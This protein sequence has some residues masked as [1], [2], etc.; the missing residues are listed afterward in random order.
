MSAKSEKI[1]ETT[2]IGKILDRN[3]TLLLE[4]EDPAYREI[5]QDS[6]SRVVAGALLSAGYDERIVRRLAISFGEGG[7]EPA[8]PL[9]EQ[10]RLDLEHEFGTAV[11]NKILVALRPLAETYPEDTADDLKEIR[12]WW[13]GDCHFKVPL[14]DGSSDYRWF[15]FEDI[16]Y[17]KSLHRKGKVGDEELVLMREHNHKLFEFLVSL[18]WQP[19]EYINPDNLD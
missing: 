3:I 16:Y 19:P 6:L 17:I 9:L 15:I 18:G 5:G 12:R 7:Q 14:G 1:T 8:D 10:V 2:G 11:A 13:K 4:S